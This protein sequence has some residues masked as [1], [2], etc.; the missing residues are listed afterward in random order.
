MKKMKKLI[1]ITGT[2]TFMLTS[3]GPTQDDALKYNDS[4][5]DITD[6][7]TETQDMFYAQ[8]DGHNIDSLKITHELFVQQAEI[9][10]EN[11]TKVK[12]FEE[13]NEFGKAASDFIATVNSIANKE[14][15]QIVELLIKLDED[16]ESE[17]YENLN[18]VAETMD[19]KY[20]KAL[21]YLK[22]EQI[23]FSKKWNYK[24]K[25]DR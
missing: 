14:G 1:L 9:S 2:L 23:A 17:D 25:L 7:L 19:E 6:K 5:V 10:S 12:I 18:N 15:K 3:C 20:E 16:N 13:K 11:L 21:N 4:I 24:L 22:K 8:F